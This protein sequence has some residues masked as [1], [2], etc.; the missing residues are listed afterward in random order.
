MSIQKS[1]PL[2]AS[3]LVSFLIL[4]L[5]LTFKAAPVYATSM[6][7]LEAGTP[8]YC[9]NAH[10]TQSPDLWDGNGAGNN[11]I[12]AQVGIGLT[13][14]IDTEQYVQYSFS[15]IDDAS[16]KTVAQAGGSTYEWVVEGQ[17]TFSATLTA[18]MGY[19]SGYT[20][21]LHS[22]IN[23]DDSSNQCF[24]VSYTIY[25]ISGV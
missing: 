17:N 2:I 10:S 4:I 6:T 25:G 1:S 3:V 12:V 13:S 18:H 20:T 14:A 8:E 19:R 11:L 7:W 23:N 16:G 5:I 15:L 24:V 21:S 22:Y 9:L